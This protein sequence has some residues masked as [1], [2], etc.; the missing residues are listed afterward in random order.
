MYYYAGVFL[1][2]L[3]NIVFAYVMK[4]G[5]THFRF[6]E[7]SIRLREVQKYIR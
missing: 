2:V 7:Y 1:I 6:V 4:G 3:I 5:E